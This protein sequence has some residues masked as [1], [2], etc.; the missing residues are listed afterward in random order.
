[1]KNLDEAFEDLIKDIHNAE[2]QLTTALPKMAK[3]ATSPDL[4]KA[5]ETHLKQTEEH[6]Q[7]VE[8][9]AQMCGFKATG[10]VC[11][12]M[13][14]LVAEAD[15]HIKE[16]KPGH[17]MDAVLI[18]AAQKVEHYEMANYGT[19]RT[20]AKTLGFK[21]AVPILQGV[22]DQEGE[23][24]QLLTKLAESHLNQEAEAGDSTKSKASVR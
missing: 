14:G 16:G 22:L 3:N 6:V 10:V 15:E 24:D 20:W 18:A 8:Q 19:A 12:A 9:V 4:K 1:M 21:E 2:K 17:T 23:T 7:K 5:F 11:K 13:Q